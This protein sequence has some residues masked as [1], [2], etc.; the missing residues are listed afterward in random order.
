MFTPGYPPASTSPGYECT[1]L[2]RIENYSYCWHKNGEKLV[3]PEFTIDGL[4]DTVW[5]LSLF[6]R[7]CSKDSIGNISLFLNRTKDEDGPSLFSV[8]YELS[9]LAANGLST[10]FDGNNR[11]LNG[12]W[13]GCFSLLQ[14]EEA[15]VRRRADYLPQDTLTVR[16]K[17]WWGAPKVEVVNEIAARTRIGVEEVSYVHYTERFPEMIP[18]DKNPIKIRSATKNRRVLKSCL[19]YTSDAGVDTVMMEIV[20]YEQNHV[21]VKRNI[22]ILEESGE[23]TDCGGA[24]NLLDDTRKDIQDLPL[25]L[26]MEAMLL[27]SKKGW[28]VGELCL[29]CEC[30]LT[31][32]LEFSKIERSVYTKP[33][34]AAKERGDNAQTKEVY[35]VQQKLSACHSATDDLKAIFDNQRFTDVE[36]KTKTRSFPAH[37]LWLCARSPVFKI[38]LTSDM[39]EKNSNVIP[40]DDLEDGTV[41]QLLLFLYTDQLEDLCW[42]SAMKLYYAADKYQIERL[43]VVCSSFFV[44][45]ITIS[46]ACELLIMADTHCDSDLKEAVQDFILRHEEQIFGSEDWEKLAEENPQLASK[47]MLMKYQKKSTVS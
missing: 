5:T 1:F 30:V 4:D 47:T 22:F 38:M 34:E 19:Y 26:T 23:K 3:S 28:F 35:N 37:Q 27:A 25:S 41:E 32:G 6:P 39:S 13:S 42:D 7:G 12:S 24:D 11:F 31:T 44:D 10:R 16:C 33:L 29:Q 36:F 8:R 46:C 40:I 43:R 45:N 21:L 14:R 2:W 20:P 15:L 17:M 9:I 18:D